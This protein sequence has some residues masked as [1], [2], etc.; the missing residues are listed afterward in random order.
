MIANGVF[1]IGSYS[2]F[3][4]IGHFEGF[5]YSADWD[6]F[7]EQLKPKWSDPH[8][9]DARDADRNFFDERGKI[10]STPRRCVRTGQS[11]FTRRSNLPERTRESRGGQQE[12]LGQ[13]RRDLSLQGGSATGKGH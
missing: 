12:Q 13:G 2:A 8:W 7:A 11:A 6:H 4:D 3:N 10:P 5:R 9:I 1:Y